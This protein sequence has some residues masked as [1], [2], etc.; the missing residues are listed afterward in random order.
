MQ[1]LAAIVESPACL[2]RGPLHGCRAKEDS[3]SDD[4]LPIPR[5]LVDLPPVRC[6]D[7]D[8]VLNAEEAQKRWAQ[9]EKYAADLRKASSA[10]PPKMRAKYTSRCF[11]MLVVSLGFHPTSSTCRGIFS[12]ENP[13]CCTFF[14]QRNALSP[15]INLTF[16]FANIFVTCYAGWRSRVW[17]DNLHSESGICLW[18]TG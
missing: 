16:C 3:Q 17:Q 6:S 15:T 2:G 8:E 12:A 7:D 11:K 13:V 4:E 14:R 18:L 10:S 5:A 1:G 9:A